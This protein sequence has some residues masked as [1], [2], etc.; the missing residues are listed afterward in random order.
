M[1]KIKLVNIV[2][3]YGD[4]KILDIPNLIINE[5]ERVGIV[6]ING[7]GKTTFLNIVK[8]NVEKAS[9]I[10][11]F[12]NVTEENKHLSGG[13]KTK[14]N[15]IDTLNRNSDILLA[16]EPSSN[17]DTNAL[18]KL[19]DELNSYNGTILLISHDRQLLDDVCTHIIEIEDGKVTK[20]KGNYTS[21]RAQK[22]QE[23]ERIK[24]EYTRY[25][26]EKNRLQKAINISKN[27]TNSL[28][29]APKRMGNS[30]ARLHK[31]ET[32]E[33]AEKLDGHTKAIESRLERLEVK[34]KPKSDIIV[35]MKHQENKIVKARNIVACEN[36]NIKL[37][38]K[39]I[40]ENSKFY[41]PSNKVTAL[42]G[43]NG[44]GKTT[45]IKKILEKVDCIKLNNQAKIGYFS[46]N[47][48]ILDESKTVIENINE[49]SNQNEIVIRNIL[50]NLLIK[51]DDVFK[52]V[53][54][55]SGGEKVKVA[56]AKLLL[57]DSNFLI[58]DEPTNY[59]DIIS[60]EA[61]ENLINSYKGTILL[62]THDR[63]L[64]E[65]VA[66]KILIIENKKIIS[67]DGNY[68]K[69]L[70]FKNKISNKSSDDKLLLDM[71]LAMLLS[72][73]S[74]TK[75][76]KEKERLEEEYKNLLSKK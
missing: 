70:E 48:D 27:S 41:I 29:K 40:I 22:K 16:D 74:V 26:E 34:E 61:L 62:V 31:R 59:L 58:L 64:I 23:K 76:L 60:I 4:R 10:K 50:G 8:E 1:E 32:T 33:V 28:K 57:S 43:N 25:I 73:I 68:S 54:T 69:Y 52:K 37:G 36:I 53:S 66:D 5:N 12:I 63:K 21:Y 13:E 67:F 2:K 44:I 6:G 49:T 75:D 3:Y 14:K 72:K 9:Y 19:K 51:G 35:Y 30:E 24:F 18:A 42:I 71:K 56:I 45:L 7:S 38:E 20:Y 15:I 11:Q 47:I 55:L 65:N 17:L 46:Q 39:I